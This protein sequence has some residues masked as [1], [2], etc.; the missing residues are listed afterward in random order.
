MDDQLHARRGGRDSGDHVA[1][2]RDAHRFRDARQRADRAGRDRRSHCH[3]HRRESQRRAQC[4]GA[5]VL[6]SAGSEPRGERRRA[7]RSAPAERGADGLERLRHDR[8]GRERGRGFMAAR[9][10]R[11]TRRQRALAQR[12][13]CDEWHRDLA[14]RRTHRALHTRR[15]IQRPR[16]FHLLRARCRDRR[17]APAHL[18]FRAARRHRRLARHRRRESRRCRAGESRHGELRL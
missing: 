1:G 8:A 16:D 18:H 12:H 10:R 4:A 14:R 11:R 17:A 3:D 6:E 5:R 13:R 9:E 7:A 15:R 2:W